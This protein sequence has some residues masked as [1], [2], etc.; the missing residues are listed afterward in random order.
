MTAVV[1]GICI[2]A[3]NSS[4]F[5]LVLLKDDTDEHQFLCRG[6]PK[7]LSIIRAL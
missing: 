7:M 3:L 6:L 1:S 5:K 4:A 2:N